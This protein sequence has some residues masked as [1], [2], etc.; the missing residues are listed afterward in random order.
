M[1]PSSQ[2]PIETHAAI[3]GL[4]LIIIGKLV[5]TLFP[6]IPMLISGCV[7]QSFLIFLTGICLRDKNQSASGI[8]KF[9]GLK[10]HDTLITML[11]HKNWSATALMLQLL[12]VAIN[13]SLGTA[14]HS[15]LILDDVILPKRR[16]HHTEGVYWDCRRALQNRPEKGSSKP[17]S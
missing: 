9:F 16:S 11:S 7:Y 10:S 14:Y 12:N 17:A 13:M 4:S 2:V 15:W 6:A 3:Y 5:V 1:R 8:A